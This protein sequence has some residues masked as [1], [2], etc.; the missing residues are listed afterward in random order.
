[1]KRSGD[2]TASAIILFVG[3]GIFVLLAVLFLVA[4]RVAPPPGSDQYT[5]FSVMGTY[6]ALAAWGIATGVGIIRLRNWARISMIVLSALATASM[7]FAILGM[8]LVMPMIEHAPNMP[9]G[10]PKIFVFVEAAILGV[11]FAI[12][13]WWLVLF[14]R[15]RVRLEFATGIA[16]AG[17]SMKISAPELTPGGIIAPVA[18]RESSALT[19][20]TSILVIAIFLVAGAGMMLLSVAYVIHLHTPNIIFGILV[21]GW[22]MWLAFGTMA[23]V[24]LIAGAALMRKR[25]W[26]IDMTIAYVFLML[27]NSSLFFLSSK[28]EAFFA[29]VMQKYPLLPGSL[30]G[31]F[32][33]VMRLSMNAGMAFSVA[34]TLVALY[35]LFTRRKAFRAA[36]EARQTTA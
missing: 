16:A 15:K 19:I 20:P 33:N 28:R 26:A 6:G 36:C 23:M 4:V 5:L 8:I 10:F 29:A 34:T 11:P 1:M 13:I 18:P 24:Q 30:P 7:L 17:I 22:T 32:E 9:P 2:V 3:S 12:A 27:L 35:F 31:S 21:S 25:L 14:T